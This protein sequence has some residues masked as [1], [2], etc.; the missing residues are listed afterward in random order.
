VQKPL[1][2]V[3]ETEA[4]IRSNKKLD[5]TVYINYL[6]ILAEENNAEKFFAT[7]QDFVDEVNHEILNLKGADTENWLKTGNNVE[8]SNDW[9]KLQER[10]RTEKYNPENNVDL[11]LQLTRE[12]EIIFSK[13]KADL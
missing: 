8:L 7:Y 6:K 2:S 1:G 9:T 12:I 11:L 10:I 3:A 5:Y 13:I 4:E